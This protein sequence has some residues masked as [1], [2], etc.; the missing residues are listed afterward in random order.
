MNG[1]TQGRLE[2]KSFLRKVWVLI[3]LKE[4]V[5]KYNRPP[6]VDTELGTEIRNQFRTTPWILWTVWQELRDEMEESHPL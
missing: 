6:K 3:R 5:E 4:Y 2:L 1:A